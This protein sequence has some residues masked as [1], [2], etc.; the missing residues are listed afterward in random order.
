MLQGIPKSS[1]FSHLRR[2]EVAVQQQGVTGMT[3]VVR[4]WIQAVRRSLG[5]EEPDRRPIRRAKPQLEALEGRWVPSTFYWAYSGAGQGDWNTAAN[6]I[7]PTGA[8]P[9]NTDDVYFLGR[10]GRGSAVSNNPVTVK[11]LNVTQDYQGTI[12]LNRPLTLTNGGD[13]EGGTISQPNGAN[14]T[15]T[16]QGGTFTI[17]DSNATGLTLNSS[18]NV[19]TLHVNAQATLNIG[20]NGSYTIGDNIENEGTTT[21]GDGHTLGQVTFVN[22]AGVTNSGTFNLNGDS[23][24]IGVN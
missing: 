1:L 22:N 24:T 10:P 4:R 13:F 21:I 23:G 19:S 7:G 14:S 5:L 16:I 3:Q 9:T 12:T 11:S 18:G 20:I 17:V 15:I 6:W 2:P 8:V